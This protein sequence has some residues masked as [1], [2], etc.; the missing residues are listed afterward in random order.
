MIFEQHITFLIFPSINCLKIIY[1]GPYQL[2]NGPFIYE[3]SFD[4]QMLFDNL[5]NQMNQS[6]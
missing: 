4:P 6:M 3:V 5:H 1:C 2:S